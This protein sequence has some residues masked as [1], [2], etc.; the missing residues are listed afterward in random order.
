MG[1][2]PE[3]TLCARFQTHDNRTEWRFVESV[4]S[5]WGL[6]LE[7]PHH[8][9]A[10]AAANRSTTADRRADRPATGFAIRTSSDWRGAHCVATRSLAAGDT[11]LIEAPI[12]TTRDQ[13]ADGLPTDMNEWMLTHALLTKGRGRSWANAFCKMGGAAPLP[14]EDGGATLK[15][16]ARTHSLPEQDVAAVMEV[17]RRNAFGLE[18][19]VLSVEYGA[20]FY[21]DA[22]PRLNHSCDPNCVSTR[23]GGNMAVFAARAISVGEELTHSYLPPRLL[24]LPRA[25]RGEYLH[26][27]CA[28]VRCTAEPREVAAVQHDLGFPPSHAKSDDGERIARFKLLSAAANHEEV[29]K[30]GDALLFRQP[31]LLGLLHERPLAALDICLPYIAAY[32]ALCALGGGGGGGSGGGRSGGKSGGVALGL[33]AHLAASAVDDIEARSSRGELQSPVPAAPT[34]WLRGSL[35]VC[36]YLLGARTRD[37]TAPALCAALQELRTLFGGGAAFL[38][39]DLPFLEGGEMDKAAGEAAVAR[40][41]PSLRTVAAAVFAIPPNPKGLAVELPTLFSEP[42]ARRGC[43]RRDGG[44]GSARV[45]DGFQ[46]CSRCRAVKYCSIDCQRADWPVH[47]RRCVAVP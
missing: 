14:D 45:G 4:H 21:E 22:A 24:L 9:R 20:A 18:T 29:L 16:L 36:C 30:A 42:C 7:Q 38:R 46:R 2:H 3:Q 39:D 8:A 31:T 11:V 12:A 32:W 33:A 23:L 10:P 47:K 17:V 37:L 43:A 27:P 44:R 19:P 1:A 25:L 15:W 28:C 13:V 34:A 35:A 41:S 26:F 5:Q 6:E 40:P